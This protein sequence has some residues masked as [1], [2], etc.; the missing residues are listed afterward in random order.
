[1]TKFEKPGSRDWDYPD[2]AREAGTNALNDAGISYDLIE[3]AAVGYCYGDST[4]GQ[5]ALYELGVT[6]IPVVNVNNNC[7]TG[8]SALYLASRFIEGGLA[9][10]TLA[11]GFEKM[12]K[13]SIGIKYLDRAIPMQWTVE[14]M[15]EK[16]GFTAAP[17]APQMFGNAGREYM[18]RYGVK[19][20]SF[21]RIAEK[22]HRHSANNPY[23]QFRDVY[24]L[25]EILASPMV[26]EPLTK[27]Q[28]CPTSDGSAAVV[29]A[30]ESFVREHGLEARAVEIIGMAMQTD[31]PSSFESNSDMKFIGFD[32]SRAAAQ[33]VYKQ[34]GYGP[35]D[36]DVIE[37]HDC[38]SANELVT[39]EAIGLCEE[40]GAGDLIDSGAVTYGGDWVV[41]PSG[42]LISKGHPLGATGLAQCAELTWQLR[43]EAE[44]RQVDD[45]NLAMQHNLGL[46]GA[47]VM[48]M[49]KRAELV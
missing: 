43:G 22:N 23:S 17:P 27:L 39:Y 24:T 1:M 36:V 4:A 8:S 49:Y 41:N 13:G 46:G 3:Q 48:A 11:L 18:E 12:E 2:M 33:K 25:D 9:D 32:M 45:V 34:S 26:H 21:A 20:E 29:L 15:N 38:F 14:K 40:G 7:A 19:A 28:C 31:F 37:L 35:T 6:G 16:R 47:C 44:A 30:S 42:G 5:R 10:C